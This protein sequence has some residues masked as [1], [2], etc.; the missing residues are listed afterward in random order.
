MLRSA[1]AVIFFFGSTAF[2]Q[3]GKAAISGTITNPDAGIVAVA[4]ILLKHVETGK[5]Y[6]ATASAKGGYT[7]SGLP[8]GTYELTIPEIGFTYARYEE[9]N[10]VLQPNQSLRHDVRL[11]WGYRQMITAQC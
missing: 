8:A 9:K 6:Q 10:I 1:V 3:G 7:I 2:A 11:G 5:L 4:R